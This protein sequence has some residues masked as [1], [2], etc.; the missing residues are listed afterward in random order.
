MDW[1]IAVKH[2]HTATNIYHGKVFPT[3]FE[4]KTVDFYVLLRHILKSYSIIIL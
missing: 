3:R 4:V 1:K 2:I